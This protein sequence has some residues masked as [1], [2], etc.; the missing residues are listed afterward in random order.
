L[1]AELENKHTKDLEENRLKL[2]TE[3]STVPKPSAEVLNLKKIQENL[4]I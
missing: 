3:L 2:E 4:G 1:I